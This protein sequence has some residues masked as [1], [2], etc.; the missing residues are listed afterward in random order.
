VQLRRTG[1]EVRMVIDHTDPFAPPA[2]PDPSLVN[3]IVN[4]HQFN[5]RLLHSGASRFADL[6]KSENLHRSYCSQIHRLAYLAPDITIAILDGRQPP[7]LT[8][9]MLIEHP[10]LPPSWQEQRTALGFA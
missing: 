1:K 10:H 5:E 8:A 7:G 2:K 9:T 4:A 6:A 3:A